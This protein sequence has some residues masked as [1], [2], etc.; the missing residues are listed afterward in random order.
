MSKTYKKSTS[1]SKNT[2]LSSGSKSNERLSGSKVN[3]HLSESKANKKLS[4]S[5]SDKRLS[6][7]KKNK[8][9]ESKSSTKSNNKS[10]ES[11]TSKYISGSKTSKSSSLGSKTLNRKDI[12]NICF[13][14]INNEYCWAKYG[15][16]EV[17]MMSET[18]YINATKLCNDAETKN[19][20]KKE[21]RFW[22]KNSDANELIREISKLVSIK[23]LIIPVSTKENNLRGTYVHPLLITPIAYWISPIFGAKVSIWI[24]EWKKYSKS[25]ELFYWKE[26]G[27][28]IPSNKSTKE[29]DIQSKLQTK[30]KG[31]IE[32]ETEFG[33]I[34]LLTEKYI[35]EIKKYDNWKCA[36]GQ[37]LVYSLKYPNKIKMIYLF[38]VSDKHQ[39]N[40]I[41]K[42]CKNY[43]IILKY[44]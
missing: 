30:Y 20:S 36:I 15:D 5:K 32:V 17:I 22:K 7:S 27:Q 33:N 2:Y 26:I 23:K 28:L 34:D 3:R 37:I 43:S 6:Q 24:E 41:K 1:E 21:F 12:R 8:S 14:E 44:E 25:N 29:Q 18:G 38:D 10:P 40:A 13:E 16:F 19:G 9:S 35:I 11:K 4:T 42:I 39:I 31:E